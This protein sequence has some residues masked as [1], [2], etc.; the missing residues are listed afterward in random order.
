MKIQKILAGTLAAIT[1]G[2]TLAF[3]VFGA[4][5]G[6]YVKTTDGTMTSPI[7]A[8]GDN[9]AARD[10]IGATDVGIALAGYATTTVAVAGVA[11]TTAVTD[12]VDLSTANTK[13][14]YGDAINSA[15]TTLTKSDLPTILASGTF[16]DDAGTTY[17][18]DQ[19]ISVGGRA[20]V[21]GASDIAGED[22][23]LYIDAGTN[24]ASPIYT[25]KVV[26]TKVLNISHDDVQGNTITLFGNEFTIGSDS[27]APTKLVLFGAA[28]AQTISEGSSV[29]VTLEG[30]EHTISVIGVSSSTVAVI[31]VDGVSKEVTEGNSY[32]ISGVDVY[33]DSV[34]YFGKE[35]QV[36]Q[37][38]L[39]VGSKKTI[40]EN[41]QP[42]KIGKDEE[43]IDNTLVTITGGASGIST[44][45][46]AV[47]AQ[48]SDEDQITEGS[49]TPYTDPVYKTFKVA[50]GGITPALDSA[51]RD[52]IKVDTT[53][54][55]TA[56]LKFKDARG[57]E[58]TIEFAYDTDASAAGFTASLV[59]SE[60]RPYH[61]VEGEAVQEKEYIVVASGD[62]SHLFQV[63]DIDNIG[64]STAKV[65]LKDVFSGESI[66]INLEAPG[67]TNATTYID[68]QTYKVNA[69]ATTVRLTWGTDADFGN[70]GNETTVYPLIK[71]NNGEEIALLKNVTL[72]TNPSAWF[73]LP[74]STTAQL[75]QNTTTSLTVGR[76]TYTL[77]GGA[78]TNQITAINNVAIND[79]VGVLVYEEKGKN[80][81]GT[82]VQDAVI[83]TV[84]SDG[85]SS[86][87]M[88]VKQPTLTAATTSG[89]VSLKSDTSVSKNIDR[90]GTM[91]SFDTDDQNEVT[92]SYPDNQATVNVAIGSD[93]KFTTVTGA[94]AA[95]VEQA[96]KIT[97]P[98]AKLASEVNTAALT[99][100][101][102]LVGGPCAN[103]LV[104]TLLDA[105]W[106]VT[107]SCAEFL[108]RYTSGQGIIKEIT[109]AFGSGQKALIIAGTDA[110][111]TR[112]LAAKVMKGTLS[113]DGTIA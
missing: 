3:S 39:S 102:I 65:V 1:A 74:G 58:K 24:A 104:K 23:L 17:N 59:D 5:L 51:T 96:V 10:I 47:A 78:T 20:V 83:I 29:T 82:E 4:G 80:I 105:A 25:T 89:Y 2:A 28:G 34:Y 45:E 12:G 109:D 60:S 111:D 88:E 93:P 7:I 64:T 15:R 73:F 42:V 108:N 100:D 101:L 43:S 44:L 41:G 85:T 53:T 18:Y 36:S 86:P 71:A 40:L 50:F 27:V 22:P 13:L 107:D 94:E 26:F 49:S 8:V 16:S 98:V 75:I 97:N 95:T 76:L 30:T 57:N 90:Y 35:A 19:Y 54:D 6:D 70:V 38:K 62:F 11:E 9:A 81:A 106:N 56:T 113:H 55:T 48:D 14:Y 99:S 37:V 77:T 46:I 21:F 52:I 91:V 67:Y 79:T 87:K 103:S 112:A 84:G 33:I 32:V 92:I 68:G 63:T 69:T 66:T 110:P 61:V 72:T 31:S